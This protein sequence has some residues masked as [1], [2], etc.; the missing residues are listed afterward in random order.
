[1]GKRRA[2]EDEASAT[3]STEAGEAT[4]AEAQT[5]GGMSS[6]QTPESN[7]AYRFFQRLLLAN[8]RPDTGSTEQAQRLVRR[9][10]EQ[11]RAH[12]R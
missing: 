1:M 2:G 8:V 3:S 4:A 11:H 7:D 12:Q 6:A 10:Y 5:P 9:A